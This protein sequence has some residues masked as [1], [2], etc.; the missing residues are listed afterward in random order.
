LTALIVCVAAIAMTAVTSSGVW[1]TPE[2]NEGSALVIPLQSP[3]GAADFGLVYEPAALFPTMPHGELDPLAA[4][5]P[6]DKPIFTPPPKSPA[7]TLVE[8]STARVSA[9]GGVLSRDE[10]EAV[11]RAA[12]AP[13]EW[14]PALLAIG[15]CESHYSP[16]A[17]GDSGSSLG[18]L[19]LWG[20]WFR[21]GEDPFDAVTN[22]R[23]AVRVRE[24]RGR[25][26]GGG[27]WSCADRLGIP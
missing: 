25:F 21:P 19:Q 15:E 9:Q 7:P 3:V 22:A 20:G 26:G 11:L 5:G 12:G 14:I 18:W 4:E 24:V 10:A 27:G 8:A 2:R 23:V 1:E 16:Y 6:E 13:E 17:K